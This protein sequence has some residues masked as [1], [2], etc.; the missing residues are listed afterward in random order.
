MKA[1]FFIMTISFIWL[2]FSTFVFLI[3]Y[4]WHWKACNRAE[5]ICDAIGGSGIIIGF[6]IMAYG[7][8]QKIQKP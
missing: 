4:G 7:F 6:L 3:E 1:G 8:I 2:Q 5:E